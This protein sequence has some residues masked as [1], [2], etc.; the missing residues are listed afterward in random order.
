MEW[1]CNCVVLIVLHKIEIFIRTMI[2]NLQQRG[3]RCM[4]GMNM[5]DKIQTMSLGGW[6]RYTGIL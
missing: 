1:F 4:V 2:P 6:K 5:I 3:N